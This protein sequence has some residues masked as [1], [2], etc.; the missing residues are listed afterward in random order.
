MQRLYLLPSPSSS[1]HSPSANPNSSFILF[2]SSQNSITTNL[3]NFQTS[4]STPRCSSRDSSSSSAAAA[5]LPYAAAAVSSNGVASPRRDVVPRRGSTSP[6]EKLPVVRR[7]LMDVSAGDEGDEG[8]SKSAAAIDAGL[9]EFAKKMRIFEPGERVVGSQEKPLAV[10]LDLALYKAKVLARNFRFEEAE[11]I[12]QKCISYWPEDGRAYVL[13]GKTLNKQSK[14]SEARAVYEKGCQATQGENPYVWQCWAV[15]EKKL[16]NIRRARELFDAATVA[17]KRHIAAWHGWAVLELKQGNIRK[18]RNLLAKALKFCGGN[19]FV[20]QTLALLEAKANRVEQARSLFRQ[21][22]KSNP[23][24]CASW[25]AWAQM[26]MQQE[27]NCAARRLFE[28]AIQASPKNR[29]A[30]H[31][32]GVFEANVGNVDKGKKLLKIGHVL[33]PRDPVLL[34]SLALLEYKHS[35]ANLA[36]VLFRRA[37]E[38]DPNHQPVWTAWGWMEWKEGN[39]AKARELYQKTLSIDSTSET[40]ARCLQAWGVLEQRIGNLSAARRLFRSSLNLNSQ[41]YITWMTWASLEEDQ[42]NAIRAEEI[43]NLY[44]QQRTEVVDDASWAMGFLDI[45]DPAIDSVKRLLKLDQN[46]SQDS[47][48]RMAAIDDD[49]IEEEESVGSSSNGTDKEGESGFDLDAFVS[50][51]LSLDPRKL[52]F[53]L[54]TTRTY[55]PKKS[56]EHLQQWR[57]AEL[58]QWNTNSVI[59]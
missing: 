53:L 56:R 38:L 11:E 50:E 4:L 52:D 21:A 24:S 13:L 31:V 41:S 43:R 42:G 51:K 39:I 57:R 27:N 1:S 40:A 36:R 58:C 55:S 14:N 33:N 59:H 17:D 44:F 5:V 47:L 46:S 25:L 37:S 32:W 6:A 45:I 49:R 9:A 8:G 10:N 28:K 35:T 18:A 48:R 19:E 22:T 3:N 20:Y 34:Q 16:G 26:E 54:E 29:F 12:L 30:W 15:L 2:F 23:R 7:P